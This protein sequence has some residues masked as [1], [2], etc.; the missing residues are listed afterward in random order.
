MSPPYAKP[1]KGNKLIKVDE[2][3]LNLGE[4]PYS[5]LIGINSNDMIC[6][7]L[8]NKQTLYL[9]DYTK[10][11]SYNEIIELLRFH[12]GLYGDLS[13]IMRFFSLSIKNN[14]LSL[15]YNKDNKIV[16]N[17]KRKTDYE[18]FQIPIEFDEKKLT[19]EEIFQ[20][21]FTEI[22]A[23]K[24]NAIN[25]KATDKENE[26]NENK[27]IINNLMIKNRENEEYIK[28]LENKIKKLDNV[29]ILKMISKKKFTK[30]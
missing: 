12:K 26:H 16:L 11:F 13:K 10:E 29:M 14:K 23:I 22:N 7:K 27:E 8:K 25:S 17:V 4:E 20:I 3:E 21:L 24:N 18:E 30:I 2:Y 15:N 6:F 28:N 9:Y 5:L 1:T 19:T